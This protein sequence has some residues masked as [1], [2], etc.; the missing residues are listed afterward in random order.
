MAKVTK[1]TAKK[2]VNTPKTDRKGGPLSKA[3]REKIKEELVEL[4]EEG[5]FHKFNK[6]GFAREKKI[7]RQ[8]LDKIL[9]EIKS[10]V[11][12][13]IPEIIKVDILK[14]YDKLKRRIHYW[15]DKCENAPE[16]EQS[17]RLEKQ[18]FEQML[19]VLKDYRETLQSL[20][21]IEKAADKIDVHQTVEVKKN[22]VDRADAIL[23][24]V[25]EV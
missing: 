23:A 10:L 12:T 8:T 17:F 19:K 5:E 11:D 13:D 2:K 3:R 7:N 14:T 20:G 15:W 18:V 22:I 24:E 1:K 4:V 25:R 9:E 16:E 21:V 6:L